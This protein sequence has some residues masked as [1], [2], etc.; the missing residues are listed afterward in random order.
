MCDDL[1]VNPRKR[2][3]RGFTLI[4]LLVVIS[5]IALLIALLLPALGR[6]RDTARMVQCQSNLRQQGVGFT[7][8][9]SDYRQHMPFR[10]GWG[11]T[12]GSGVDSETY[13]WLLAPY[14]G[15]VAPEWRDIDAATSSV[16]NTNSAIFWCPSAPITGKRDFGLWYADGSWGKANGY[17]GALWH[18][19]RRNWTDT[20]NANHTTGLDADRAAVARITQ[21]YWSQPWGTPYQFCSDARFPQAVGGPGGS[22][23]VQVYSSWHR[24]QQDRTR[25][26][27]FVDA[28]VAAL[29]Q[30]R[31]TDSFLHNPGGTYVNQQHPLR[32][33]GKSAWQLARG[34]GTPASKPWDFWIMEY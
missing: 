24:S 18:H 25:P 23:Q 28:H 14:V 22:E 29:T 7:A 30:S 1:A 10:G 34:F 8:Y 4:E 32:T 26:T 21:E 12:I 27:L 5:I 9:L 11:G 15:A 19:Y 16:D 31:Y 20:A 6:V 13:E 2:S 33:G 3:L 17:Q